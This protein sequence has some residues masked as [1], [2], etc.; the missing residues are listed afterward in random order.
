MVK[1]KQE[2]VIKKRKLLFKNK[3][4]QKS[5]LLLLAIRMQSALEAE[6][7]KIQQI[8]EGPFIIQ[9]CIHWDTFLL[10]HP[11]TKKERGTFNLS[12]LKPYFAR[13]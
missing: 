1:E 2:S 12:L 8:Y 3:K 4:P 13:N 9:K 5:Q 6:S 11:K 7:K 10:I